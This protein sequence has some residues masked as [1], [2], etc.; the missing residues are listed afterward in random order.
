MKIYFPLLLLLLLLS[1][2]ADLTTAWV[3]TVREEEEEEDNLLISRGRHR[4]QRAVARP[5]RDQV[6]LVADTATNGCTSRAIDSIS[7]RGSR[8]SPTRRRP[9][10]AW[11]C[12]STAPSAS[13]TNTSGK[14]VLEKARDDFLPADKIVEK[15][16]FVATAVALWFKSLFIQYLFSSG[17][18]YGR[19]R[20]VHTGIQTV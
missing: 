10:C 7:A 4:R 12:F 20:Q 17:K 2:L 8:S 9:S 5:F 16:I 18:V 3:W 15:N 14:C 6:F 13:V 11:D 19:R 1:F